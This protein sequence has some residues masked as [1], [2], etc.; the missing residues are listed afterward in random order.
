MNVRKSIFI[1]I[2]ILICLVTCIPFSPPELHEEIEYTDVVYSE[3]GKS[4]T[5]YLDGQV[6]VS[7]SLNRE[8]AMMGCDYFEVTFLYNPDD[9]PAN[10]M[11][12]RGDWM[13][14]RQAGINGV[15][16]TGNVN[17][18]NIS[19]PPPNNQGSAILFAGK[20]DK[21]LMAVGR[22]AM[23]DGVSGTT[24]NANTKSVTFELDALV[25]AVNDLSSSSFVTNVESTTGAAPDFSITKVNMD[26][27]FTTQAAD[28]FPIFK[29]D[30]GRTEIKAQYTFRLNSGNFDD[31]LNGILV[32]PPAFTAPGLPAPGTPGIIERKQPRYTSGEGRYHE[33]ILLL[34]ELTVIKLTNNN[35]PGVPFVRKVDFS[36]DTTSTASGTVFSLVFSIPVYALSNIAD[37]NGN[38]SKNWYIR[39]SYGT[40][41]YDLDDGTNGLG[42]AVLLGTGD[43]KLPD[44]KYQIIIKVPPDKW[45]Y[46]GPPYSEGGTNRIF[47]INGLIV[48]LATEGDDPVPVGDPL[49]YGTLDFK[50]GKYYEL[51]TWTP[52][53]TPT[54]TD[55]TPSANPY[56]F[57]RYFYGLVEV[58]VEYRHG[59]SLTPLTDS[60]YVL[61]SNHGVSPVLDFSTLG[62]DDVIH[63]P[64][65]TRDSQNN[66]LNT[67]NVLNFYGTGA[68]GSMDERTMWDFQTVIE[69]TPVNTSSVLVLHNSFN[70][71]QMISITGG[72]NP[73]DN[74]A[75]DGSRLFFILSAKENIVIG[76]EPDPRTPLEEGDEDYYPPPPP[77]LFG[78]RNKGHIIRMFMTY[79][80]LNGF[81]FGIWPFNENTVINFS[82]YP[83]RINTIGMY[84]YIDI[85]APIT[86]F[87]PD[88]INKMITTGWDIDGGIY[89]V[90]VG[91]G[92]TVKPPYTPGNPT[93][94][95]H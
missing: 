92:V 19:A 60:F 94:P 58:I 45:Q 41:L 84:Q 80:G 91:P 28:M 65:S 74:G 59:S 63:I 49:N 18:G 78:Y 12:A 20:S 13:I 31:Y 95:L 54:W 7:R 1:L 33:S 21:T 25:A 2:I 88:Y 52:G 9:N 61:V 10:F 17:Y 76:R 32:A 8:F 35:S 69:K 47:N 34:D 15:Y 39:S 89:N 90:K 4:L 70:L 75:G 53:T 16:R 48:I 51:P 62:E 86:E 72:G 30:P 14:G 24:I 46:Y 22:I 6:P 71:F 93:H 42:G 40:N 81:Y 57:S 23:V 37:E 56:E 43:V 3:D 73:V 66:L 79:P 5:I 82:T 50:I 29:L 38:T 11:V 85:P 26:N 27:I 87:R 77:A 55:A 44:G 64:L 67:Q 68:G 36:F 83:Y